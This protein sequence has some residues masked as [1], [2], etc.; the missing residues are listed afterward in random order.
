MAAKNGQERFV[1]DHEVLGLTCQPRLVFIGHEKIVCQLNVLDKCIVF[2]KNP[3]DALEVAFGLFQGLNVA[4][5]V[6][7]QEVWKMISVLVFGLERK[8]INLN[9]STVT[10]LN[11]ILNS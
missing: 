1:E 9:S 10:V 5:P 8:N 6:Q 7:S 2:D 4:Y 11:R 3:M